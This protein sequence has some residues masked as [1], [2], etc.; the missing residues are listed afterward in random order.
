MRTAK[1]NAVIRRFLNQAS[2]LHTQDGV[3]INILPRTTEDYFVGACMPTETKV[4][5]HA[6]LKVYYNLEALFG[7][8]A[9]AFYKY[10]LSKNAILENFSPITFIFLHELGHFATG[11]AIRE[12]FPLFKRFFSLAFLEYAEKNAYYELPDEKAASEWAVSW[13]SEERNHPI[14]HAFEEKFFSFWD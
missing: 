3:K 1:I 8:E 4:C 11:D 2:N 14:A 12:T 9:L 10:W 6:E 5:D 13:L 7:D